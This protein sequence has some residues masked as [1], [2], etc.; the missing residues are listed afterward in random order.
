MEMVFSEDTKLEMVLKLENIDTMFFYV[1]DLSS[2]K[3]LHGIWTNPILILFYS[4]TFY[5]MYVV[6]TYN[7]HF[8]KYYCGIKV[9][10]N[11]PDR[12]IMEK[13]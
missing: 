6:R 9:V 11:Y 5:F 13:C 2:A 3:N 1:L 8:T 10:V 4:T 12:I 7:H